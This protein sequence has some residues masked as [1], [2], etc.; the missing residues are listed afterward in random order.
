MS[1]KAEEATELNLTILE[2]LVKAPKG[3]LTP[4]LV[5][6]AQWLIDQPDLEPRQ[7]IDFFYYLQHEVD[8]GASSFIKTLV[9]L[10]YTDVACTHKKRSTQARKTEEEAWQAWRR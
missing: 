9:N 5:A 10:K 4:N 7:I 1:T 6:E 3:E 8:C 2:M